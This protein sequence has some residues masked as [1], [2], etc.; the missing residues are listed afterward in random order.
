MIDIRLFE[1]SIDNHN[2]ISIGKDSDGRIPSFLNLK[3]D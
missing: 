1:L 3:P 2:V